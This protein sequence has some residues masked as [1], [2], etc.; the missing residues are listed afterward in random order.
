LAKADRD[1][2]KS[3]VEGHWYRQ[4]E[5]RADGV[6]S[7]S[8]AIAFSLAQVYDEA[9]ALLLSKHNDYGP[10][11]IANAP[12]GPLFGLLVRMHD[13]QARAVHLVSSDETPNHESLEDTFMDLLNYAAIAILVLRGQWPGVKA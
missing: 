3:W 12:F 9:E 8:S 13:K 7:P 1:D 6:G 11:N 2:P 10:K 4:E 5:V